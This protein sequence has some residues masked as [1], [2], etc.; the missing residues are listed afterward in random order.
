[1]VHVIGD[2][3]AV[4]RLAEEVEVPRLA[5]SGPARQQRGVG[6]ERRLVGL[7]G[8]GAEQLALAR[9]TDPPAAR[10]PGR[11]G[12]RARPRRSA[13]PC[14]RPA[15]TR[16]AVVLAAD[17]LDR[18]GEPDARRERRR[19]RLDVAARPAD[20]RLP[21]RPVAEA[22][23]A[24]VVEELGEEAHRERPERRRVGRPHRGDLRHDQPLDEPA[25][26]A[27]LVDE[28]RER[29]L[30]VSRAAD[31]R[32][33]RAVEAQQVGEHPPERRT[34]QVRALAEDAAR[35]A[36]VL[37]VLLLARAPRSPCASAGARRRL[38]PAARGSA[39]SCDR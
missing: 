14:R 25:R 37:E 36:G 6:V 32:A 27:A 33:Q 10:A 1:M 2:G 21:A 26:V 4:A 38:P 20:H 7:V 24:V 29:A 11:R 28:L 12:R 23:H 30:L 17:R 13:R 5:R 15:R 3:R 39:G 22:E 34:P 31:D 35:R 8:E 18:R 9:R 19:Q 16:D